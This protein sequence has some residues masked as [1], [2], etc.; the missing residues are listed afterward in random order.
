M[1]EDRVGAVLSQRHGTPAKLYPC[2]FF[3]RK[4]TPAEVNYDIGNRELLTV[5]SA[6]KEWWHWLEGSLH[7]FIVLTDHQY[8]E[9]IWQAKR[10]NFRQARWV[11]FS[12]R[13]NS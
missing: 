11:L 3:L 7:P 1:L 2:A 12:T 8:L 6:L 10:L 4:L 13:F 9:Y 5:K